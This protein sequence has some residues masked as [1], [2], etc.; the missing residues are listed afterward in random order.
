MTAPDTLKLEKPLSIRLTT[1]QV[2]WLD[3]RRGSITSRS[4]YI[5]M[6]VEKAMEQQLAQ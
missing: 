1:A 2:Q 3:L 4:T 6:L 5:R